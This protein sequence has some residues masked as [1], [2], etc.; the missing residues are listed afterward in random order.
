M[1]QNN[2]SNELIDVKIKKEFDLII[3]GGGINGA[4][5]ACDAALRGLTYVCLNSTVVERLHQ[6]IHQS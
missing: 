1:Q 6:Q 4:A 3:I 2:T 5:I